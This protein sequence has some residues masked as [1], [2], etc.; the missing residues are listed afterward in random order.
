M[1]N[2]RFEK[3]DMKMEKE[4]LAKPEAEEKEQELSSKGSRCRADWTC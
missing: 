2:K 3:E 4:R 1:W